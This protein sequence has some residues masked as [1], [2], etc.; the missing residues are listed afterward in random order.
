MQDLIILP[1]I[2]GRYNTTGTENTF[3]GRSAGY[4]NKVG[5]ENTFVGMEAGF[6]N[7]SNFNTFVG[8]GAGRA[9]TTGFN[10][11]Y[12]G[13]SAGYSNMKGYNNTFLGMGTGH[14]GNGNSNNTLVGTSSGRYTT[15]NANTYLG[16]LSGYNSTGNSNVFIGYQAGYNE[17]G[18]NKLYID[19]NTDVH[20]PLV[21]G[22]FTSHYVGIAIDPTVDIVNPANY[23]L[24]V[25]KGILTEKVK[26]A[27]RGTVNWADYVFEDDY[28]LN[29]TEEVETFIKENKHLPNVPSAKQ[30]NEN[31]IDVAEMDATLLRQIEELWLHV[32]ELKKENKELKEEMEVLKK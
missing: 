7:T 19:N 32:I 12:F 21:Y 1:N 9:N 24:Y 23:G 6:N 5:K 3:V 30:V 31:G 25:G 22:D 29:S 13:R 11:A 28:D 26:V 15:G 8:D 2:A 4:N 20:S 16:S 10:N 18:D 17:L 14:F 27:A